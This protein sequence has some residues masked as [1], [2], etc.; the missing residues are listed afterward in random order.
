MDI[1]SFLNNY[2]IKINECSGKDNKDNNL[3]SPIISVDVD[4][5]KKDEAMGAIIKSSATPIEIININ[6]SILI[7]GNKPDVLNTASGNANNNYYNVDQSKILDHKDTEYNKKWP[8]LDKQQ[9]INRLM[10]YIRKLNI[11]DLDIFKQ[12]QTLLVDLVMNKCIKNFIVNYCEIEGI[13]KEIPDLKQN[14]V[15][16]LYYIGSDVT[17]ISITLH[18]CPKTLKPFKELNLKALF[19]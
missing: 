10:N 16:K 6:Q 13:I 1:Y 4:V 2:S 9:K 7:L 15:T 19:K 11:K 18:E 8:K 12:L 5:T 14:I 3:V 17:D